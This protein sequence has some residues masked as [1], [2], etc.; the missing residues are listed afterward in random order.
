MCELYVEHCQERTSGDDI[1]AAR[2]AQEHDLEIV[3]RPDLYGCN[4]YG[5]NAGLVSADNSLIT[6][7]PV[8]PEEMR[9]LY[10]ATNGL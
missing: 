4:S 7:H 6:C 3:D 9:T 1:V 8:K 5:G 2:I 10:E